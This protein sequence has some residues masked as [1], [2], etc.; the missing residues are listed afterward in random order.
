MSAK[1]YCCPRCRRE[2]QVPANLVGRWIKCPHCCI[3]FA[4]IGERGQSE[5]LLAE[6]ADVPHNP[7]PYDSTSFATLMF[8]LGAVLC[9]IGLFG[10]AYYLLLFDTSVRGVNNL[11]LLQDRQTG[12]IVCLAAGLAG[13]LALLGGLLATNSGNQRH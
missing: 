11:G 1:L 6:P 12:V 8:L 2:I 9:F 5:P 13:V 10:T 7:R 4:V 3:G